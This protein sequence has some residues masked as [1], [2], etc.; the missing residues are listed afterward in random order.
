[1]FRLAGAAI[2]AVRLAGA[3]ERIADI[4][5]AA[6][7][8]RLE[9]RRRCITGSVAAHPM[10]D[11]G[12]RANPAMRLGEARRKKT[13]SPAKGCPFFI[14]ARRCRLPRSSC[15]HNT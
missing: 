2:A 3:D 6:R 5:E 13:G 4:F 15:R 7:S 11:F 10:G 14:D 1:M 9:R 12:R 8:S